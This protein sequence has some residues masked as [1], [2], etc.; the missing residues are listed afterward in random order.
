MPRRAYVPVPGGVPE[1]IVPDNLK[2]G[3]K[4]PCYYDPELNPAYQELAE[5][6]A[7]V[8]L[9]AWVRRPRDYPE[10]LQIPN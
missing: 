9:P 7:L 5:H 1:V 10:V 2:S 4:D 8:V 3:V 6:Y